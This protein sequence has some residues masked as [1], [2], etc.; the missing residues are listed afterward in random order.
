MN[1]RAIRVIA[2]AAFSAL[3]FAFLPLRSG[4]AAPRPV[5]Q[6][7]T[8]T[9][10][11]GINTLVSYDCIPEGTWQ[12]WATTQVNAFKALGA[13]SI[14]IG[15]PIYTDSWT[16]NN[17]YSKLDCAGGFY[18]TPPPNLVGDIVTI[19]HAAGLQ[20][21]VR[22]LLDQASLAPD[23]RWRGQ[24]EPTNPK[25]WFTNYFN[26]LQPYLAMAQQYGVEHFAI[27]TELDSMLHFPY[28]SQVIAGAKRIYTGDL[29]FTGLWAPGGEKRYPG[30]SPGIDTYVG[31]QHVTPAATP[32][33]LLAGWNKALKTFDPL[34]YMS[35]ETID[36]VTIPAQT[37]AYTYPYI[38]D[39]P[40]TRQP[41]NQTIQ[42][43]W[44]T[45]VC[46]FVKS[47]HLGGVYFWGPS[48]F[49]F[50]GGLPTAPDKSVSY[51]IQP[52]SQRVLHNCFTT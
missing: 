36:E 10:Q 40:Y 14:A 1:T 11:W 19:A 42:A 23:N 25:L 6:R 48:I 45:M 31:I 46:R 18:T 17:V 32:S 20:V 7:D 26:A 29:V 13:N 30:T 47:H 33:Q 52:A 41:F 2:I 22:P 5:S 49:E 24:I 9:Y 4:A 39:V 21:L 38:F 3:L 35:R 44:F 51:N 37:G 8:P 16:S 15:I 43:N 50:Q 34:P 27:A 12:Q 28:W